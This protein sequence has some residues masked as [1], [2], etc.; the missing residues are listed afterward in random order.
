[1][2]QNGVAEFWRLKPLRFC[3]VVGD[4][5]IVFYGINLWVLGVL[6]PYSISLPTLDVYR[7][8][9]KKNKGSKVSHL[10]S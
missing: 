4:M 7:Q 1:M 2:A 10:I 8:S 3:G 5:G 6:L 9:A